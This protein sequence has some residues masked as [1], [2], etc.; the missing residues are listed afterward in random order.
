M[1]P[2]SSGR[3]RIAAS[4]STT[5]SASAARRRSSS[6]SAPT[7]RCAGRCSASTRASN[8]STRAGASSSSRRTPAC[9]CHSRSRTAR[10]RRLGGEGP[11][12]RSAR[13]DEDELEQHAV[14]RPCADHDSRGTPGREHPQ[15]RRAGRS[16]R[17]ALRE[18]H[19]VDCRGTSECAR[20]Y[21]TPVTCPRI[22]S[23]IDHVSR[24]GA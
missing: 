8:S 2:A 5:S 14:R 15:V 4:T 11:R 17:A 19:V 20:C 16:G 7:R 18:L 21:E 24:D 10:R 3:S 22:R 23:T 12:P 13:P 1:H 9:T 6:A